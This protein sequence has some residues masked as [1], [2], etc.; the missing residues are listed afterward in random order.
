MNYQEA[1]DLLD[2]TSVMPVA[3]IKAERWVNLWFFKDGSS[4]KGHSVYSTERKARKEAEF[5]I[6][7]V[8]SGRTAGYTSPNGSFYFSAD[9]S[10]VLQMPVTE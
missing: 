9:F 3:P 8:N 2:R 6:R 10:F 7:E 5:A 4:H 1:S